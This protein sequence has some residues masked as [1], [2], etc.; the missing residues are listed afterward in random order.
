VV[1]LLGAIARELLDRT[2]RS[3]E[4]VEKELGLGSLGSLPDASLKTS[5]VLYGSYYGQANSKHRKKKPKE[6]PQGGPEEPV[7]LLVHTHPKS[8]VSEAARAICTNLLF[9]SPDRPLGSLLVTSAGPAE[10]KTTIAVSI[11]IAL[12]QTGRRVCL[13]DCDL[14]RPRIHALFGRTLEKGLTTALLDQSQL[15]TAATPTVVPN[16]TVLPAGP[17][18]PNPAD[19]IHSKAFTRV[20]TA[21]KER[22]D[23]VVID[24]PPVCVVTD[25]TILSTQ[26][27]AVALVVRAG[28]T[29]RDQARR[30]LRT[31]RDVGAHCAGFVM[32]AM[33]VPSSSYGY[34]Y[35]RKDPEEGE[36]LQKAAS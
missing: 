7:E 20:F 1:G 15:D 18:P 11:A 8:A 9:M 24:S 29:R 33:N 22:F 19:L 31:L 14:R 36:E 10:G 35:Y 34:S 30:A 23:V 17:T 32:N 25:A 4:D 6:Q 16:L 2:A 26:T 12:S 5:G 27:E 13:V 28:R 21:L 3:V